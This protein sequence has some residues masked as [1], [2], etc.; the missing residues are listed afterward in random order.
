MD[1]EF[2]SINNP[3]SSR[4]VLVTDVRTLQV[5]IPHSYWLNELMQDI[6]ISNPFCGHC[7]YY[8]VY[9]SVN[10]CLSVCDVQISTIKTLTL[11]LDGNSLFI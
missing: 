8:S 1:H 9:I 4:T 5:P 3:G 7:I 10:P 2:H 6:Y 11:D